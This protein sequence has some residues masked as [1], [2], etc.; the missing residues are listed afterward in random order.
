M[1]IPLWARRCVLAAGLMMAAGSASA[2]DLLV[3]HNAVPTEATG[4][5]GGSFSYVPKVILNELPAATGV[6]LTQVLPVGVTLTGIDLPTG[7]SC[8]ATVFP[9]DIT[10]ANQ[11]IACT[12][13]DI[14]QVGEA[15]GVAVSFNV[16]IPTVNTNWLATAS[17]S[18][19]ESSTDTDL[20]NQTNITRNITTT[21]A[22]DVGLVVVGSNEYESGNDSTKIAAGTPYTQTVK[23][24]NH[25]PVAIPAAGRVVVSFEV[26]TGGTVTGVAGTGWSCSYD[27]TG[28]PAR[29][30]TQV[31]CA[32]SG[33]LGVEEANR[34]AS[35]L[36]VTGTADTPD[37]Q[38]THAYEVKAYK[39][40]G[41]S[42]P[43]PDGNPDNN[44][45]SS[46]V[47]TKSE[48][49]ADM[50][51]TKTRNGSSM[52]ALGEN[53]TFTIKPRLLGGF[54][55]EGEVVTVEDTLPAGLTLVSMTAASPWDCSSNS[56]SYTVPTGGVSSYSDLPAIKVTAKVT[57]KGEQTNNAVVSITSGATDPV[58]D[59]NT[60]GAKVTGSNGADLSL[61]KT[62][63]NYQNGINVAVPIGAT[64]QYTLS[65]R[66]NGPLDIP[67]A[68]GNNPPVVITETLPEG[69]T[70]ESI[71]T[72][73]GWTC[74]GLPATG[75]G[76]ATFTCTYALGIPNVQTRSLILNAKRTTEGNATNRACVAFGTVGGT[77]TRED[78]NNNNNC[79]DVAV[80]AS[81]TTKTDPNDKNQADLII[82]KTASGPV[83]A[84]ENLTYTFVIKNNGPKDSENVVLYD[85]LGSL[86]PSGSS[87][88]SIE[89][90][91]SGQTC[92]PAAPA[93]GESHTL[94]CQLG[95]LTN[96]AEQTISVTVRPNVEKV[97]EDRSNTASIYSNTTYD[98]VSSNNSSPTTSRV[99]ARVNLVADKV[100]ATSESGP[101][102]NNKSAAAG[103][104]M[105]YTVT[106]TN[107]G[108]SSAENVWLRD[109]LPAGAI[110]EGT[111]TVGDDGT[112]RVVKV[113]T[114]GV[115]EA[116]NMTAGEL[117]PADEPGG[118]LECV[119]GVEG[120]SK[121]LPRNGNRQ[122]K[123]DLRSVPV[124]APG[125]AAG[126]ELPNT[127]R[128]GT[129]TDEPVKTDNEATAKVTLTQ[130]ELDV[131]INMEHTKDGMPLDASNDD[132]KTT[133]YTITV[134]NNGPSYATQMKMTDVFPGTL[135]IN[136]VE[137]PST[138]IFSYQGMTALSS[139][140]GGDLFAS[141][142]TLCE[143]PA[144]NA[145]ANL[146]P[147]AQLQLVCEFPKVAPGETITIKFKMRG[148]SLPEGRTT[149][150]IFHN[151]KV[152]IYEQEWLSNGNDT[153][154][155][156]DT[157][158]RTSVRLRTD[159]PKPAVADLALVKTDDTDPA[160]DPLEPGA[161]VTYSL[162]VTNHG[163]EASTNAV[164]TDVLPK[165]LDYVSGGTYDA[166]TR[167]VTFDVGTLAKGA[168]TNFQI[169]ATIADPYNGTAPLVNKACVKGEGDPNP[170]NDCGEVKTPVKPPLKPT[171]V[172]V[173]NPLALLALI[174]GMGWIAR[175][176][177]MRKHA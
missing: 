119:W 16:T 70:V 153:K 137:Y 36:V 5:A 31:S 173:D 114:S 118:V 54:L 8:D 102:S 150:T 159:T 62:A 42:N 4:P 13:P 163:P 10:A 68:G 17:A 176:F 76:S 57:E 140:V 149:G 19:N 9:T 24:T 56:C 174:L 129:K 169:S 101:D 77:P 172:P 113:A 11:T 141:V 83:F 117:Q 26:A 48:A 138:A 59:N 78:G 152:E 134:T 52:V 79:D 132:D 164:V 84:G 124:A 171:P 160:N 20:S 47:H 85:Q 2:F 1:N 154:A 116:P 21:E 87:L 177:H 106:V 98:H 156:N 63:S 49:S 35:D 142:D 131:L 146:A 39:T 15:N 155:N 32:R 33:M 151:A 147:A 143:Q 12:L 22:A 65:V 104:L 60:A 161:A 81:D 61:S 95:T 51:I 75:N 88:V 45:G 25:G 64:Y 162:T 3:N 30:G 93:V 18:A 157:E 111:P 50:T 97:G 128:V 122:V 90:L 167:T 86:V 121:F 43:M 53:T 91:E 34:T 127:V 145:M 72:D 14:T 126:T 37:G 92:T 55:P 40:S 27:P 136:G 115:D 110:L 165:G 112:C 38:V 7:A 28:L 71:H 46:T 144:V 67:K 74:A 107:E 69:V 66:N 23:V 175:R 168:S 108:P 125:S 130:E 80:G 166:D 148:E 100:V 96:G 29:A 94:N 123:Y 73:N 6:K 158:D 82:T 120:D 139:S 135:E 41:T 58:S 44:T 170:G 133:E 103:S 109:T 105:R 89:G 99:T